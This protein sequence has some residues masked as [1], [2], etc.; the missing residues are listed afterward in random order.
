M[1]CHR[2]SSMGCRKDTP[3]PRAMQARMPDDTFL[4]RRAVLL[5]AE[6]QMISHIPLEGSMHRRRWWLVGLVHALLVIALSAILGHRTL[7]ATAEAA[8]PLGLPQV[9]Q[10]SAPE[11]SHADRTIHLNFRN[12]DI[13]QM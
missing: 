6:A 12:V 10:R 3:R 13:L 7:L 9:A 8:P 2:A 1:M 5:S 11:G 4:I